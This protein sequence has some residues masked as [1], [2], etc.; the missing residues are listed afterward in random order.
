MGLEI[1][2]LALAENKLEDIFGYYAVKA[3]QKIAANLVNGIIDTTIGIGDQPEIG[4]IEINLTHR[5]Q[6]FR[7]ANVFDTRQDPEKLNETG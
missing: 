6:E 5:K 7:Y 2:W 4:P 1:Y 3:N